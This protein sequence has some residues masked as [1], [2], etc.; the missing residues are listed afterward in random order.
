VEIHNDL[1][2]KNRNLPDVHIYGI[3][4]NETSRMNVGMAERGT[5]INPRNRRVYDPFQVANVWPY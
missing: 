3:F 1:P 2:D 5:E 4:Y